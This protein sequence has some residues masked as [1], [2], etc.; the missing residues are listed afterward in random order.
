M[1]CMRKCLYLQKIEIDYK[2]G[3]HSVGSSMQTDLPEALGWL[4]SPGGVG[5]QSC[6]PPG[7]LEHSD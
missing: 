7:S 6:P 4:G 5:Y 2:E 3:M 1:T